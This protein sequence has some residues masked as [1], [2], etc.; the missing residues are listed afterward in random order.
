ME[1]YNQEETDVANSVKKETYKS[2]RAMSP[3]SLAPLLVT[4]T[5][6]FSGSK[7]VA[8]QD[9]QRRNSNN[10]ITVYFV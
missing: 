8:S 10:D 2:P 7:V 6:Q 9:L 1:G 3:M 4:G 5:F